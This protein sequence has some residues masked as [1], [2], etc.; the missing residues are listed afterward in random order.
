MLSDQVLRD[1]AVAMSPFTLY[2]PA[3]AAE[4]ARRADAEVE[5]YRRVERARLGLPPHD[6]P[7]WLRPRLSASDI[8]R[9]MRAFNARLRPWRYANRWKIARLRRA[10]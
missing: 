10:E 8:R 2:H 5:Q 3:L 1:L 7:A 6:P 4:A 9:K